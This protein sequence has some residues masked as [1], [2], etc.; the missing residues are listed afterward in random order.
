MKTRL[1]NGSHSAL[2]Y[3][4]R[5]VGH[6]RT[7]EVMSDEVLH[8][9]VRRLMAEEI[10][11]QLSEPEGID[12]AEYQG[13]LLHRFANPAIGDRLDRLCRRGST[14]MPKYLLP[15]LHQA[16]ADNRPHDLLALAVAGWF[17]HLQGTDDTGGDIEVE[18]PQ[19]EHLT[20]LARAGGTDPGP[21]LGERSVFGD[22]V[23]HPDLVDAVATDLRE[24][25]RD[26]V[27]ATVAAHLLRASGPAADPVPGD[28][29]S[30]PA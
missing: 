2:G 5:L 30:R 4:G 23:D 16:I 7:D 27:R 6:R 15:S 3:L 25:E 12:L 28:A 19:A 14:R 11:P 21:L 18:D 20:G 26:G 13:S 17:R 1:L 22:L 8:E 9:Y 24:M 10:A 29:C